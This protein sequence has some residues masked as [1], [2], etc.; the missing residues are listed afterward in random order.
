MS[1][2]NNSK[3]SE[4]AKNGLVSTLRCIWFNIGSFEGVL[5][6]VKK[7]LTRGGFFLAVLRVEVNG[8]RHIYI[9]IY[10]SGK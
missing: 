1:S 8:G 4:I 6:V 2:A 7:N 10:I 3:K 9:Y 5:M